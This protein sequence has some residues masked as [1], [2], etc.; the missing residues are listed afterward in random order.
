[1]E[2]RWWVESHEAIYLLGPH[3]LADPS[4]L[5]RDLTW[6]VLSPT[7][8]VYDHL[9]APL[10]GPLGDFGIVAAG[11]IACW[12]FTAWSLAA[13]TGA[14]ALPA[15]SVGVGYAFWMLAGQRLFFCGSPLEGFQ[16]K[17]FAYP[18]LFFGLADAV[19]GRHVRAGLH[20]GLAT[21]LH[22]VVGGWGF[23]G[24][25]GALLLSRVPFRR[26]AGFVAAAAPFVLGM[27]V[28]LR[29]LQRGTPAELAAM[30]R[31]YVTM[32][33]PHC[34]DPAAFL[35]VPDLL[36]AAGVFVTA[37]AL[38]LRWKR[39]EGGRIAGHFLIALELFFVLGLAARPLEAFG[40]LKLYPFQ[41]ANALPAMLLAMLLPAWLPLLGASRG[42][43]R[44]T[45]ALG[46]AL[47][48]VAGAGKDVAGEVAAIPRRLARRV[49]APNHS[50]HYGNRAVPLPLYEWIRRETPHDAVFVTPYLSEFWV[51][52]ERAQ[53]A[54]LRHPPFDRRLLEWNRRLRALNRDEPFTG[55]GLEITPDL[56][57]NEGR[58]SAAELTAL[59]DS[60][61][62]THYIAD[63]SREDLAELELHAYGGYH[64]YD[65]ARLGAS[66]PAAAGPAHDQRN[67]R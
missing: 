20:S 21:V 39:A 37:P 47:A 41:L 52:A 45:W 32:A 30:D 59:R 12:A 58:L 48:L 10:W 61:G 3:R 35:A 54:S 19:R 14:L 56:S 4:F 18:F 6:S 46:L 26:I 13:L 28:V 60:C 55:Q 23:L 27:A 44:F 63:T 8:F 57:A 25:L 53:V 43:A 31:L 49:P 24:L 9:L 51:C 66:G 67:G 22:V 34:C 50:F 36:F 11:R 62:A 40:V 33:A 65:L 1:M 29:G 7:T 2:W 15:W 38:I 16:P 42:S 5:A 17:A 64:V